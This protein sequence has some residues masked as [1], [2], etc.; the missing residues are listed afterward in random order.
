MLLKFNMKAS[1]CYSTCENVLEEKQVDL[2]VLGHPPCW[3]GCL[4]SSL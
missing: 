1:W 4:S 3:S 2:S